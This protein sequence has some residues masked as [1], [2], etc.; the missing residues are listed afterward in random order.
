MG[1]PK[2][3]IEVDVGDGKGIAGTDIQ[4]RQAELVRIRYIDGN[5]KLD[6]LQEICQ[7]PDWQIACGK[8]IVVSQIGEYREQLDLIVT[9]D[10]EDTGTNVEAQLGIIDD[11]RKKES[12]I[13]VD[14]DLEV[15]DIA[16]MF[17]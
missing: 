7:Y 14:L 9:G 1:K 13:P 8:R 15:R 11:T 3:I 5:S 4:G 2:Q 17:V 10:L 16:L 12:V 6:V